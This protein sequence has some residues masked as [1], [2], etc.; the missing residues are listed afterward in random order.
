[1]HVGL[2]FKIYF[3][4]KN[5][6]TSYLPIPNKMYCKMGLI[7]QIQHEYSTLK[8]KKKKIN[9]CP[10]LKWC[11]DLCRAFKK[12]LISVLIYYA[13]T[14]KLSINYIYFYCLHFLLILS[15]SI[16]LYFISFLF[17]FFFRS[18]FASNLSLSF[19]FLFF[20]FSLLLL[21]EYFTK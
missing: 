17:S 15:L 13:L 12:K 10:L 20:S 8:F 1:M 7:T 4:N 3:S 9:N 21:M 19:F 14:G 6:F 16:S 5:Q 18:P 2:C 11:E